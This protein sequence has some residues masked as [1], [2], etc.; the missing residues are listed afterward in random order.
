MY[1]IYFP[2]FKRSVDAGVGSFMCSYN[3][4]NDTYA[5]ENFNTLTL[6]LKNF[7]GFEGWVMSDWFATHS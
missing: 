7:M 3:R 6:A 1:E 2:A 4:I 5:C